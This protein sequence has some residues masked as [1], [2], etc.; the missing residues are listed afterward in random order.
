MIMSIEY[1]YETKYPN[2]TRLTFCNPPWSGLVLCQHPKGEMFPYS[3]P[4]HCWNLHG[5]GKVNFVSSCFDDLVCCPH[6]HQTC[7]PHLVLQQRAFREGIQFILMLPS[8]MHSFH[9][10]ESPPFNFCATTISTCASVK[11]SPALSHPRCDG[12]L[13]SRLPSIPSEHNES[14]R[15]APYIGDRTNARFRPPP[16]LPVSRGLDATHVIGA[17]TA[18]SIAEQQIVFIADV[19]SET[20]DTFQIV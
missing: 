8:E 3:A 14:D 2:W 16:S 1:W 19:S 20:T 18:R 7:L 13:K 5:C 17:V 12:P 11:T 6:C 4:L 9:H 10:H 15:H